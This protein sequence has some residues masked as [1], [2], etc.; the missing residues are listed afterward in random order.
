MTDI[1][2]D[3]EPVIDGIG[4]VAGEIVAGA[5]A[6]AEGRRPSPSALKGHRAERFGELI[7]QL[8]IAGLGATNRVGVGIS[9]VVGLD[10]PIHAPQVGMFAAIDIPLDARIVVQA[11]EPPVDCRSPAADIEAFRASDVYRSL[12]RRIALVLADAA[13]FIVALHI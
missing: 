8:K 10:I 1:A 9:V 6:Q 3:A 7:D 5:A 11:G 12:W 13:E 4:R 2:A